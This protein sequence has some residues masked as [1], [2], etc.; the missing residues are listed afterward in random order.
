MSINISQVIWT[1]I[2][3]ALFALVLD[4]LLIRPVLDNIDRRREKIDRAKERKAELESSRVEAERTARAES[5][6]RRAILA[7]EHE[8]KLA[9]AS[10]AAEKE[11]EALSAELRERE[12]KALAALAEEAAWTDAKLD[13]ATGD[14]IGAFTEILTTGGDL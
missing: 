14:M 6:E 3:F 2:C 4:R 11:L 9:E 12:E 5:E 1:I 7:K 13:A 10:A 8:A